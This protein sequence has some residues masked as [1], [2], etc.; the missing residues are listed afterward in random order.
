MSRRDHW[1]Q[2][3]QETEAVEPTP[4]ERKRQSQD[5]Q[6]MY[7][8]RVQLLVFLFGVFLLVVI[9][10]LI[11]W[12]V[13]GLGARPGQ[14]VA[15]T[16]DPAR[17]RIL[18]SDGLLLATDIFQWEISVDPLNYRE[19][20]GRPE[21]VTETAQ[22]I[23][24]PVETLTAALAQDGH[25]APITR[26]ATQAQCDAANA[27]EAPFWITCESR[28]ERLHPLG[29]LG[30]HILG[31][32]NMDHE[33]LAGVEASYNAWLSQTEAAFTEK[34]PGQPQSLPTDWETY[35]PSPTGRDLVLNMVA[36]LQYL[37]EKRL[38]EAVVKHQAKSGTVIIMD[39]RTG[40]V[41]ALANL[42]TFH[43]DKY[44]ESA[45]E[46][47]SNAAVNEAYEPGSVMKIVTIGGALDAKTITPDT[48][49]ND[50]GRLVINGQAIT[51]SEGRALGWVTV[52]QALASS[53][54]VVSA[55]ICD[56]MGSDNFYRYLRQ[57]GFGKVTEIDLGPENPGIVKRPGSLYWSKYD[58]LANSFGQGISVTPLQMINATAAIANGGTLMQPQIVQSLVYNGQVYRVPSRE[59]GQAIQPE[60]ARTMTQLM[61]YTVDN[62]A[63]G[64]NLVPGY[65]VA[66]KT[67]TAE[68]PGSKGYTSA[69]TIVSFVGFLPA[70]D[71]QIVI[72]VKLVEPKTSRWAEQVALPV[73]SQIAQDAVQT[74]KI[75]PDE[76]TP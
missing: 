40:A 17:G 58:Q 34:L 52:R 41:L 66:G 35:L 60:T 2:F 33:G 48:V 20:K 8:G 70:A 55:Q 7:Q 12:Q 42:P 69:L 36:P 10:R 57:F 47:W 6:P 43:P 26:E 64:P 74:L 54:N 59:L 13:F 72:L 31:F 15:Q 28:R 61:T 23:G 56:E 49:F 53:L 5:S 21:T 63:S 71:P 9:A 25:W 19:S 65:R 44:S 4:K 46:A 50:T 14:V 75:Q 62:Y 67:G 27:E 29:T 39:P 73:F 1:A 45:P 22:A 68:I 32:T 16:V 24:V 51:N 38:S 76:R 37:A 11:L 3:A 30:A 18:S